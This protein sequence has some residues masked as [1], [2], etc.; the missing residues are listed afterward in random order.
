MASTLS[1][2]H[3]QELVGEIV[4]YLDTDKLLG[5]RLCN[6]K[7]NRAVVACYVKRLTQTRER[8]LFCISYTVF[9]WNVER[10]LRPL[11]Q[12]LT[13]RTYRKPP[14]EELAR[15]WRPKHYILLNGELADF[16]QRNCQ[17]T[18]SDD[19][20]LL[21]RGSTQTLL[22]SQKLCTAYTAEEC[23][24]FMQCFCGDLAHFCVLVPEEDHFGTRPRYHECPFPLTYPRS[25]YKNMFSNLVS[26]SLNMSR[27]SQVLL[28]ILF[29]IAGTSAPD[30]NKYS[31]YMVPPLLRMRNDAS[32]N[33]FPV[34]AHL[35]R[36]L[37]GVNSVRCAN[38]GPGNLLDASE[39]SKWH[40][41]PATLLKTVQIHVF[42]TFL[43]ESACQA[44]LKWCGHFCTALTLVFSIL[45]P[46]QNHNQPHKK[47]FMD[48]FSNLKDFLYL[49]DWPERTLNKSLVLSAVYLLPPKPTDSL[50]SIPKVANTLCLLPAPCLEQPAPA[51]LLDDR[52]KDLSAPIVAWRQQLLSAKV[53]FSES[54][55]DYYMR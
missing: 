40:S 23:L 8:F 22:A 3:I 41:A 21:F 45:P 13:H 30:G 34:A 9:V 31:S 28:A 1:P 5:L 48:L 35:T 49:E 10:V 53:V 32:L 29:Q 55:V 42:E 36:L 17:D 52:V 37:L 19:L 51:L 15:F 27:F 46:R 14:K 12:Q 44:F 50:T 33:H 7:T 54:V 24:S 16:S 43:D 20:R 4:D 2:F 6:K 38:T 18:F 25:V 11:G 26:L 47:G 39:I